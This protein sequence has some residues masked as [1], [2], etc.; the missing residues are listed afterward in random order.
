MP[1]IRLEQ[2][3]SIT[4]EGFVESNASGTIESVATTKTASAPTVNSDIT[5]GY[6][7]GNIWIDTSTSPNEIYLCLDNTTGAAVWDTISK[8][9][10]SGG[11]LIPEEVRNLRVREDQ[12]YFIGQDTDTLDQ[13]NE[14]GPNQT[15]LSDAWQ[16]V[17]QGVTGNLL[18][19]DVNFNL[20][21]PA[22]TVVRIYAGEG[23]GGTLLSTVPAAAYAAGWN[24][25]TLPTPPYLAVGT[26][27]T[28]RV[29]GSGSLYWKFSPS[30]N[31][32]PGGRFI[33][34][35]LADAQF[36][37][38]VLQTNMALWKNGIAMVG[39]E[40]NVIS[41]ND[42]ATSTMKLYNDAPGQIT[43]LELNEG[44]TKI[45]GF[46]NDPN[47]TVDLD[48][49]LWT[50]EAIKAQVAGEVPKDNSYFVNKVGSDSNDG[51]SY[52]TPL[53][54]I[55]TAIDKI[56][57]LTGG[58]VPS[59]TNP[60]SIHVIGG[61]SY[62]EVIWTGSV[63]L[64][65]HVHLYLGEAS[66]G[67]VLYMNEHSSVHV[68][69]I[70]G[71]STGP[72]TSF[73]LNTGTQDAGADI[74]ITGNCIA[75]GNGF[76]GSDA[77]TGTL[78][79]TVGGRL[80][81]TTDAFFRPQTSGRFDIIANEIV[82]DLPSA[83][84]I[85]DPTSGSIDCHFMA[86]RMLNTNA[87]ASSVL[88]DVGA[89]GTARCYVDAN[90][91]DGGNGKVYNADSSS[92]L[93]INTNYFDEAVASTSS[94]GARVTLNILRDQSNSD[95]AIHKN[96]FGGVTNT[97]RSTYQYD[98]VVGTDT[99][100]SI[101]S[102]GSHITALRGPTQTY[103]NLSTTPLATYTFDTPGAYIVTLKAGP[104]GNT[105]TFLL[106]VD[107]SVTA[108]QYI[109]NKQLE[110]NGTVTQSAVTTTITFGININGEAFT[111]NLVITVATGAATLA[112]SGATTGDTVFSVIPLLRN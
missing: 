19:I 32:Y 41:Q 37:T 70:P 15:S 39:S 38:Y 82:N 24:G 83:G 73:V 4:G 103:T 108:V 60:Y 88:F 52:G 5:Q 87:S 84:I 110:N 67:G 64:P 17:T 77:S 28:I 44:A 109:Y 62:S 85:L 34:S 21:P 9:I 69:S 63:T 91:I 29:S 96:E 72:S 25:I 112:A 99:P 3:T 33:S 50:I 27:F 65:S 92:E 104:S 101:R 55:D 105:N 93:V 80:H 1:R 94:G 61:G 36:R 59:I 8:W 7:V 57:A 2:L 74:F 58:D 26:Q 89:V 18:R 95:N 12:S 20:T 66:W 79:M 106:F 47:E 30:S 97:I 11:S 100:L 49:K 48:K 75:P 16:S 42:S 54:T 43:E 102:T 6:L 68:R 14:I 76:L 40:M 35:S 22:D 107:E 45:E 111:Y 10:D 51:L 71:T 23:T 81:L 31:P 53:L 78:R 46:S 90:Y 98:Y 86:N 13:S 56:L